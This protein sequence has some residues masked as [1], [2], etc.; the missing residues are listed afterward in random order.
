MLRGIFPTTEL[1]DQFKKPMAW[2]RW[3]F[4]AGIVLMVGATAASALSLGRVRGTALLG[5]GLDLS[6]QGTLEAQEAT[7]EANCFSADLFYGETRVSP[8]Q[9]SISPERT[10]SGE[11][12]IR[13]RS[14]SMVDEPVVTL[15][16][17]AGCG[18]AVSRRYVLLS[19]TLS[20]AESGAA[21][22]LFISPSALPPAV[23]A[24]PR[25]ANA[26]ANPGLGAATGAGGLASPT[27]PSSANANRSNERSSELAAQRQAR[28]EAR[29]AAQERSSAQ[30]LP[31][32]AQA[33]AP[34]PSVVRKANQPKSGAP[35]LQVDLL[36]L[37]STELNLRGSAELSS[38]P[39]S[40]ESLRR[41]AQALWRSLNASPEDTL[42]D[43]LRLETLESQ[44]R[45][46]LEQSK[47][48][49]QDIATLSSELQAAQRA[50]YL[51]PFSAF[52]GVLALL[53]LA[54]S[55]VL[56]R[57]NAGSS[58]PWWG[59]AASQVNPQDEEH[60]WGHLVDS[61]SPAD[62]PVR[63]EA[64]HQEAGLHNAS[65]KP[66]APSRD[67][68]DDDTS[69]GVLVGQGAQ[70]PL[71]FVDKPSPV[72]DFAAVPEKFS[73]AT[74]KIQP[75]GSSAAAGRGGS[76]GRVDSTPPPSLMPSA[77]K[78]S[79]G[80]GNRSAFAH[81]DFASSLFGQSRVAA[82]EELFD[83]Q[84]QADFFMS[85]DQPEQAIEVLKNHITENVE[86]SALAYMDLFDIYHR[87]PPERLCPTA[88]RV[89][90][91]LQC[92]GA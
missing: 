88:R 3:Q 48:Q 34:R 70:G 32:A 86:T 42:R 57:R 27:S 73:I 55:F 24:S 87:R 13:I 75:L 66:K 79:G 23:S 85:L 89:Q 90:S 82:A 17:R 39:S 20:E 81:S 4:I 51:N 64:S 1:G 80:K 30:A 44:M 9:I 29:L 7:P 10:P 43:T 11:L 2:K 6:V 19:E 59:S 71:R 54:L 62:S 45:T 12:R 14:S 28:R 41:Q 15:F 72:V 63:K 37:T 83:I 47:R 67:T 50:R 33:S 69:P 56:W 53:A 58:Q 22:P 38:A 92:A 60:L 52:L 84:E 40:D 21:Q 77:T 61:Q 35:R 76:M 68:Q 8:S 36:D 91:R 49:G 31:D 65:A 18:A 78:L 74:A 25:S 16:L 46:A 5:R 26:A